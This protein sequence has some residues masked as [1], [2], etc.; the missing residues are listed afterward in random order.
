MVVEALTLVRRLRTGLLNFFALVASLVLVALGS[1]VTSSAALT[2]ELSSF[3]VELSTFSGELSSFLVELSSSLV[4]FSI[5][6]VASIC[7]SVA[8]VE[9]TVVV[10][11]DKAVGLLLGATV[12]FSIAGLNVVDFVVVTG[13]SV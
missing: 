8:L 7:F 11:F 12:D 6:S 1:S 9:D 5:I 13:C 2:E 4:E 10:L 3:S